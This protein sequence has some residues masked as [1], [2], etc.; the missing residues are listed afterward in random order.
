MQL[1]KSCL[2]EDLSCFRDS[3]IQQESAICSQAFKI[4]PPFPTTACEPE[5]CSFVVTCDSKATMGEL[6]FVSPRHT[7]AQ[8]Y[9]VAKFTLDL[10]CHSM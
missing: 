4:N 2:K 8:G 3:E 1:L 6:R 10:I 7:E 5:A 9:D